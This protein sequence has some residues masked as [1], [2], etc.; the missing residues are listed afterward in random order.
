[1]IY[2]C[3]DEVNADINF[4]IQTSLFPHLNGRNRVNSSRTPMVN[5]F[6]NVHRIGMFNLVKFFFIAL[7]RNLDRHTRKEYEKLDKLNETSWI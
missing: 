1:M 2:I 7:K 6:L 5:N 4:P 3:P